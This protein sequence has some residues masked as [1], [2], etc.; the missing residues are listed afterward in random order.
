MP[1]LQKLKCRAAAPLP[2]AFWD[3]VLILTLTQN[4]DHD[5]NPDQRGMESEA[6]AILADEV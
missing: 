4:R 3:R 1:A 5:P 6:L 2:S